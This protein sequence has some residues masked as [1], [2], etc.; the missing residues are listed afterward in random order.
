M[1]MQKHLEI[2]M[3]IGKTILTKLF[4]ILLVSF[5]DY[6]VQKYM[7]IFIYTQTKNNIFAAINK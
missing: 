1:R 2:P 3:F 6:P 5:D 4:D 7:K